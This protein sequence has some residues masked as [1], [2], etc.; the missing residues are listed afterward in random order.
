MYLPLTRLLNWLSLD[1]LESEDPEESIT[2]KSYPGTTGNLNLESADKEL[3]AA[4]EAHEKQVDR[5]NTA[6]KE[7]TGLEDLAVYKNPASY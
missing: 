5:F 4:C 2:K 3:Q 7:L 6:L 1:K